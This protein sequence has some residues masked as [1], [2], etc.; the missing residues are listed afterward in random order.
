MKV[1]Q[2]DCATDGITSVPTTK[3]SHNFAI[4]KIQPLMLNRK[5]SVFFVKAMM[6]INTIKI[7]IFHVH[8]T[9]A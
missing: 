1:W 6:R 5:I 8:A 4:I 3:R 7:K 2:C 9:K